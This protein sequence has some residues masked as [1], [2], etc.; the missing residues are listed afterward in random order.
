[1]E[2]HEDLSQGRL[3][4]CQRVGGG[5]LVLSLSKLLQGLPLEVERVLLLGGGSSLKGLSR[6]LHR[7]KQIRGVVCRKVIKDLWLMQSDLCSLLGFFLDNR[8][9]FGWIQ[10]RIEHYWS[11]KSLLSHFRDEPQR[12]RWL[13][14]LLRLNHNR[15]IFLWY[16]I[17]WGV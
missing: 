10:L 1:M 5:L 13:L 9:H 15:E 2:R 8:E 4:G 6:R 7:V 11:F 14:I 16:N 3:D 12:A 17:L